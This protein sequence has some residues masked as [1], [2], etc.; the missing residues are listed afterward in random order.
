MSGK[1]GRALED[2]L[3]DCLEQGDQSCEG[4]YSLFEFQSAF[5][6]IVQGLK[7]LLGGGIRAVLCH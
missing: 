7:R 6:L 2:I 4:S 5:D 1:L 3:P